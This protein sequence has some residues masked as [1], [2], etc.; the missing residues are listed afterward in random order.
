MLLD[1]V[2]VNI[3]GNVVCGWKALWGLVRAQP[4]LGGK[5]PSP[6]LCRDICVCVLL[7][8]NWG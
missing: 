7:V 8:P 5:K 4:S 1:F 2:V 6:D 3:C